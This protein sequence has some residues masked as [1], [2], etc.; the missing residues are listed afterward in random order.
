MDTENMI[1]TL[2]EIY[3]QEEGMRIFMT[4][5]PG[6][7]ADFQKMLRQ[8]KP[9]ETVEEIY[10]VDDR[11][12]VIRMKGKRLPSGELQMQASAEKQILD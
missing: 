1:R 9:D 2:R 11:K 6:I 5:M 10:R 4:I 12:A 3:G 8:A 7:T